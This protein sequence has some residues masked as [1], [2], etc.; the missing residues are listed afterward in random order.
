MMR[1]KLNLEEMKDEYQML[2]SQ[3][4]Y[5][6]LAEAAKEFILR[7][8]DNTVARCLNKFEH[9]SENCYQAIDNNLIFMLQLQIAVAK[10]LKDE[11]SKARYQG[12]LAE[13]KLN[14]MLEEA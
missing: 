9:L 13:Q 7:F 12:E 11:V 1:E 10:E 6:E 2:N 3:L 14:A 5:A 4:K 8:C